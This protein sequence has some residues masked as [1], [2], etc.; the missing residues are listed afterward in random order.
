MLFDHYVNGL[1]TAQQ[2]IY[3]C[4]SYKISVTDYKMKLI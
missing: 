1:I 3:H 2:S 4:K